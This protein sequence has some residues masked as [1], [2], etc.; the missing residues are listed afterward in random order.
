V[1]DAA[2]LHERF[3]LSNANDLEWSGDGS[4]LA[5]TEYVNDRCQS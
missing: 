2:N 3:A 4:R 1:I 5:Y